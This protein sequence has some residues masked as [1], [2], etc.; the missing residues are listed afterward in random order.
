MVLVIARY[1]PLAMFL[2]LDLFLDIEYQPLGCLVRL[3][4]RDNKDP[5][6]LPIVYNKDL[7]IPLKQP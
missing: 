4:D 3:S 1:I 7:P 5:V 2:F 6:C